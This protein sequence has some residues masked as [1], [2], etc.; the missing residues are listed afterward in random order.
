M[1]NSQ[2][3]KQIHEDTK[4]DQYSNWIIFICAAASQGIL[5]QC[6]GVG[7]WLIPGTVAMLL[8]IGSIIY[9]EMQLSLIRKIKIND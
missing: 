1:M 6:L 8:L 7:W 2:E 9:H 3:L 4:A 5:H